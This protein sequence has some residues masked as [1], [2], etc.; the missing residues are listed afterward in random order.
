MTRKEAKE[1][2]VERINPNMVDTVLDSTDEE[3]TFYCQPGVFKQKMVPDLGYE[4]GVKI[5]KQM[6][7]G[8]TCTLVVNGTNFVPFAQK[9]TPGEPAPE[10]TEPSYEFYIKVDDMIVKYVFTMMSPMGTKSQV[11]FSPVS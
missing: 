9:F 4:E 10:P 2:L 3:T 1:F 6:D 11:E 8:K 7:A 5:W